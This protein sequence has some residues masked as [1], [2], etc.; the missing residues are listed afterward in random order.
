[1]ISNTLFRLASLYTK[2]SP[3]NK[4]KGRLMNLLLN[5]GLPSF[6]CLTRSKDGRLFE[7]NS[8]TKLNHQIYFFGDRESAATR[9]VKQIVQ[10]GD[11]AFDVGANVGWYTTLFS[12]LVGEKGQ[13]YALEPVPS[14]FAALETSIRMNNCLPNILTFNVLCGE[15][16]GKGTIF[17]FPGLHPG[18]S[19]S[20]SIAN[21]QKIE[22][23]L[24]ALTIDCLA[25]RYH[26]NRIDIVKIDVEGA[27]LSV[28]RGAT[29]SLKDG[30][31]ICVII[32]A[33]FER[34][35]AFGYEFEECLEL[36]RNLNDFKFYKILDNVA[37]LKEFDN[38]CGYENGDNLLILLRSSPKYEEVARIL[39]I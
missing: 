39:G 9:L 23:S 31:I 29:R 27:E 21:E 2:Y 22:H 3:V 1:M 6:S 36:M 35:N 13:V 37:G 15:E 28:L 5:S 26:I 4:G 33:N 30:K 16:E 19:S 17:E 24:N 10:P 11:V 8:E 25:A 20:R 38:S 14:T 18:L 34:A 7:F 12:H 32:E